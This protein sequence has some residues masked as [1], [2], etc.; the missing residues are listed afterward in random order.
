MDTKKIVFITAILMIAISSL[1]MVSAGWFDFEPEEVTGEILNSSVTW[2]TVE[3]M[4]LEPGQSFRIDANGHA[5]VNYTNETTINY[6]LIIKLNAT[7][8]QLKKVNE[9]LDDSE[10]SVISDNDTLSTSDIRVYNSSYSLDGNILTINV[11]T[12]Y[13]N[14]YLIQDSGQAKILSG[15]ITFQDTSYPYIKF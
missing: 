4:D 2:E 3:K 9:N 5:D 11:T 14:Y 6:T 7:D 8:D 13:E 12:T 15:N 1:S 10:L